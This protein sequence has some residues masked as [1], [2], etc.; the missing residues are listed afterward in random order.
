M[1]IKLRYIIITCLVC[2]VVTMGHNNE[3]DNS[4][5]KLYANNSSDSY[6]KYIVQ[7]GD[8]ISQI[9][10]KIKGTRK[11]EN[12]INEIQFIN[13]VNDVIYPGQTLLIPTYKN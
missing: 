9:A 2:L 12:V 13:N 3:F 7:E 11:T 10:S 5:V 8:C 6:E 4:N 1:K